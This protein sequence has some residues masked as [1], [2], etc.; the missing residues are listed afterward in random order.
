MA[1]NSNSTIKILDLL[2]EGPIDRIVGNREGVFINE[3]ALVAEGNVNIRNDE[4]SYTFRPGTRGQSQTPNTGTQ[5]ESLINISQEV[6]QNYSETLNDNNEVTLRNYGA[7][8]VVRSV[9]DPDTETIDLIFTIPRLFSTAA[10]GLARGQLFDATI[11]FDVGIRASGRSS[12]RLL[13]VNDAEASLTQT[14]SV[15]GQFRIQGISTTAYQFAITGI[16]LR[17]FGTGPWDI[18]VRKYP[19]SRYQ[20]DRPQRDNNNDLNAFTRTTDSQLFEAA[21]R[22]FVDTDF[23][24]PLAGGRGNQL[25]WASIIQRQSFRSGYPYCAVVGMNISTE[26]AQS[27]PTRAYKIRGKKVRIPNNAT[28]RDDGSLLFNG[29]FDGTLKN[30]LHYTT[31]PVCIFYDLITNTRFGAGHFVQASNLS[32]VDLYSL[33]KYCNEL[34][35]GKP[36]FAC[37]V[38]V[39]SQQEAFNVL[40]DF[41]SIFRGMIYW[42]TNII[43]LAADHGNL[44]GSTATDVDPVHVFS[45][46]NV[47]GGAFNY[48]G[49]SLK[50]RSTSIRIR[51]NDPDNFYRPNV[52]CIEDAQLIEKYGYQVKEVT[53]FG[54]TSKEQARRVGRWMMKSEELN[55]NTITFSVGLEGVLVLP[56]QV[57]AVADEM[58]A[59][60]RL[61]GRV[62]SS[63]TT[64]IVA[65]QAITLPS[66]TNPKLTC[67][68]ASGAVE[69]KDISSDPAGSTTVNVSSAFSAAPL[70]GTV[71]SITTDSASNQ[72]FRCLTVTDGGDGSYGIVGVSFNDSIYNAVDQDDDLEFTDV[73][74][75][76]EAPP[77][78]VI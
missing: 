77:I 2:C 55:Q 21:Y 56:G 7:G 37:N 72:K 67:V 39:S 24:T 53:A 63:T 43:Q 49:S 57:F 30:G 17:N 23:D 42:N 5:V 35:D 26:Y 12:F 4:V 25:V 36:R 76:D 45:N 47:V 18:R 16:Q 27:L 52:V 14:N 20:G 11:F 38:V 75:L 58:R 46:S 70:E 9:T 66:G 32:W 60:T 13:R 3:T 62:S 51:Y 6:G 69:T 22:D 59:G 64:S 40:Q 54:C 31:C 48:S 15:N 8:S 68:L 73:T 29:D 19:G 65:D 50:T 33:S 78:P 34:I 28:P 71:Y 10:E 1:L 61:S 74:T 44:G 41:A